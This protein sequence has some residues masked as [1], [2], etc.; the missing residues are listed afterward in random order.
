M[1]EAEQRQAVED[2]E[3]VPM[4]AS[5]SAYLYSIEG[6]CGGGTC[7]LHEGRDALID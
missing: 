5:N 7:K 4:E 2:G 1:I 6:C 3:R